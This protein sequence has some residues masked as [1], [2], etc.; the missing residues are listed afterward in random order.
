[1]DCKSG[2][3]VLTMVAV[4]G[5]IACGGDDGDNGS[6]SSSS[7]SSGG[8]AGACTAA[9]ADYPGADTFA[10]SARFGIGLGN[11]LKAL[12]GAMAPLET[13]NAAGG[14]TVADLQGFYSAAPIPPV[15][16]LRDIATPARQALVDDAIEAFHG[17]L[18]ATFDPDAATPA[19]GKLG[20]WIF[21]ARGV[22]LRQI[23]EKGS[24]GGELYRGFADPRPLEQSRIDELVARFGATPAFNASNAPADPA[25]FTAKYASDRDPNGLYAGFEANAIAAK[26]AAAEG[27][28]CSAELV[29]AVGQMAKISEQTLAATVIYYLHRSATQ[30][31][32]DG[33]TDGVSTNARGLHALGEVAGFLWGLRSLPAAERIVTDAQ[34]DEVLAELRLGGTIAPID[35]A[36]GTANASVVFPEVIVLLQDLYGFTDAQ[37]A[38]FQN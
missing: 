3:G 22:D 6:R 30:L 38:E 36:N 11:Q 32:V 13:A 34:L 12:N 25:V 17:A 27:E 15:P 5:V 7:S 20:S 16:S 24:F 37:V 1:M 10:T 2:L 35:F 23:V 29:A 9:P 21:D 8:G 4:C 19:A 33:D 31:D 18:G 26:H 14:V 28:A